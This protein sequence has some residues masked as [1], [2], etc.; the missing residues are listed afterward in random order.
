M[1]RAPTASR[2]PS[3]SLVAASA[4][5]DGS[6][7]DSVDGRTADHWTDE[8]QATQRTHCQ[9]NG[10]ETKQTLAKIDALV[11]TR[12]SGGHELR[13]PVGFLRPTPKAT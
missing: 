2:C 11:C 5:V 3:P 10:R 9:A 6:A 13:R 4:R 8:Q 12:P 1:C 7:A